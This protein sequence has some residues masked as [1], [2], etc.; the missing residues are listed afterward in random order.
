MAVLLALAALTP[1]ATAAPVAVAVESPAAVAT[2]NTSAAP[3]A[4]TTEVPAETP[5]DTA[6]PP[7]VVP[8][9][10]RMS[11]CWSCCVKAMITDR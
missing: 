6:A 1:D 11:C 5:A 3:T 7:Q 10:P 8:G 4:E 9:W 2:P